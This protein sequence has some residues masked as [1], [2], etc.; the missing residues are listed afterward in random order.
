MNLLILEHG[1]KESKLE[2]PPEVQEDDPESHEE[3]GEGDE[4]EIM[5]GI[6]SERQA[7]SGREISLYAESSELLRRLQQILALHERVSALGVPPRKP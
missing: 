5:M 7:V 6:N 1:E 4:S 2:K 3:D